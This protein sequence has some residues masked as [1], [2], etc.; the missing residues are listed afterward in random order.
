MSEPL[1]VREEAEEDVWEAYRWY[2]R[3]RPGLG[4]TFL[5]SVRACLD[6]ICGNPE[7]FPLVFETCRRAIVKRFPYGIFYENTEKEIVVYAVCHSAQDPKKWR[8]R[9]TERD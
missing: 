9:L 6:S 7:A 8:D 1:V 4:S 3:R 5:E 2:E